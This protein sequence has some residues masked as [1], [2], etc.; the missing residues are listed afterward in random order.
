MSIGLQK[1]LFFSQVPG[2]LSMRHMKWCAVS[3]LLLQVLWVHAQEPVYSGVVRDTE[4]Q[5]LVFA[6]IQVEGTRRGVFTDLDGKFS[7]TAQPGEKLQI[8]YV[9]YESTSIILG[10]VDIL[11]IVLESAGHLLEEVVVRPK[12]NPAWRIIRQAIANKSLHDPAQLD[13]YTYDAYHKTVFSVDS[14]DSSIPEKPAKEKKPTPARIRR[15]SLRKVAYAKAMRRQ[16][17]FLN[18]MHLWVTETRSQHAYRDPNQYKETVLAT[19]SSMPNDFTGGINPINFQPFGF[20]QEVIR[21]EITD[22][23]YVNPISKGTFGHYAFEMADTIIH[24]TDTTYIIQFGPLPK[25]SFV[26]LKGLLYINT[27][28]YAI[29]NVIAE[30]ADTTQTLQFV[31]QQQSARVNGRWFP[32]QLNADLFLQM[33][34]PQVFVGYGFR[35]RSILSNVS[36]EAPSAKLF[37]HYRKENNGTNQP[38]VD[39]LRL[40][41]LEQREANTYAYWDSLE[42]LRPAY[43]FLKSYNGIIKFLS[44]GLWTGRTIDLVVPD[45]WRVN[46]Y[47]GN[48]FGI[49]LKTSPSLS[50]HFSLYG[51]TAYGL[52]DKSW[53]YGGSAEALLYRQR[54][55]RLRFSYFDDLAAP[56]DIDYL[57]SINNPWSNFSARNLVL[58]R[59]DRQKQW[60]AEVIYRPH[61]AWQLNA[62]GSRLE[63]QLTYAYNYGETAPGDGQTYELYQSGFRVRW[64]PK[65][66]LIKMEQVEAILFPTFPILDINAEQLHWQGE[67]GLVH[68]LS[69]RLT[70]EQRWKYLGTTEL[71]M[72]AGWLSASVPYPFL[73]QAPGNGGNGISGG[74]VFNTAGVTE[75]GQ[76]YFAFLFLTHRFGPLLGRPR[77]RYFRPELRLVQQVGWGELRTPSLHQGIEFSDMRHTYL[78]S[79]VGLDNVLRIPYFKALYIG[80]GATVWYRWGAYHLPTLKENARFQ[81]TLNLSV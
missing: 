10:Q 21:M 5:P 30:P 38:V 20:Y 79:G 73:F 9:G 48:R 31:I 63:R 49:G 15:D 25:K 68:R 36:L 62:F 51:Y 74:A 60:R 58:N 8:S 13:G 50:Q 46:A 3:L 54:D 66:Q 17:L 75:F 22:Q 56:G 1:T 7:L 26:A 32:Q 11:T 45:L 39:S 29:E 67:R 59:L 42:I 37:N 76:D 70:H 57:S 71:S 27:D 43:R 33:G 44:S 28:G 55:L 23:N 24:A 35:N 61:P 34:T 40:L 41:P 72:Q 77:S 81:L 12:E 52:Q 6:S 16:E 64:A 2:V 19:Q 53:K 65:E 4:G 18:E 69:A 80:L 78:E 14:L 47:E